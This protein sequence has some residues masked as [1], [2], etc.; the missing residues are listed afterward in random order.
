MALKALDLR[1]MAQ[2]A[3]DLADLLPDPQAKANLQKHAD[4][5]EAG[6]VFGDVKRKR[7][8]A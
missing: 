8:L 5:L 4:E 6:R 1:R 2:Q 3:R 7:R